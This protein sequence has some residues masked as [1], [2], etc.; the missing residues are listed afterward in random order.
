MQTQSVV[1]P[2][3]INDILGPLASAYDINFLNYSQYQENRVYCFR[4][5]DIESYKLF[6]KDQGCKLPLKVHGKNSL[7]AWQQFCSEQY[8]SHCLK[9]YK[10]YPNGACILLKHH[11]CAEH[12]SIGSARADLNL[13]DLFNNHPDIKRKMIAIIRNQ[14][15]LSYNPIKPRYH[16]D[17]SIPFFIN[18][19]PKKI[20]RAINNK[21]LVIGNR[22]AAYLNNTEVNCLVKLSQLKTAKQ[23]ARELNLTV[24]TI[25]ANIG[26][27]KRKLDAKLKSDLFNI[28]K[29]NK[30]DAFY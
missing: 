30:L 22:G 11:D 10:Q 1:N 4:S 6:I 14:I 13:F 24:K 26:K 8:L 17:D 29:K 12:I 20:I 27:I 2:I 25:E 9:K 16:T 28:V 19:K 3:K 15:N 23:M 5:G 21:T 18:S 7:M